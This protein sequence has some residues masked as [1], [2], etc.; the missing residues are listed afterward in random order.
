MS[1]SVDE[2]AGEEEVE[3]HWG[4]NTPRFTPSEIS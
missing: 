3:Q 1:D 4:E 2:N